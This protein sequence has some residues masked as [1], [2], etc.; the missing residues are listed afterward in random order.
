M[1]LVNPDSVEV[2]VPDGHSDVELRQIVGKGSGA[3]RLEVSL[4]RV[5][6]G[7]GAELHAHEWEQVIYVLHGTLAVSDGEGR[8][9]RLG[10]GMAVYI[11]ARETHA[12]QNPGP[13]DTV[14]L[15]FSAPL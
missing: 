9:H 1:R 3:Q 2:H 12:T 11:P 8:G 6:V 4:A 10:A 13:E 14:Y 7:G 5:G 15:V